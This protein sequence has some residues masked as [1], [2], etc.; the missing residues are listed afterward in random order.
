MILTAPLRIFGFEHSRW[1]PGNTG[2]AWKPERGSWHSF[3]GFFAQRATLT[4][5]LDISLLH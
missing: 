5:S 2:W 4:A 1:M 3:A